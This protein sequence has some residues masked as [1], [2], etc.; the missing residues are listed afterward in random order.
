MTE[1]R[2]KIRKSISGRAET[3]RFLVFALS[4]DDAVALEFGAERD[5]PFDAA[6]RPCIVN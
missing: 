4:G 5:G 6:I 2:E 1:M 3:K